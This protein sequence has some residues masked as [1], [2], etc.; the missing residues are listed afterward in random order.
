[1]DRCGVIMLLTTVGDHGPG[2]DGTDRTRD[3]ITYWPIYLMEDSR[4]SY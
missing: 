2:K 4:I 3:I 1:M